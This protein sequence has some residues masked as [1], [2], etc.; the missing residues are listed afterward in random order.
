MTMPTLRSIV[1]TLV[2]ASGMVVGISQAA[3]AVFS[4]DGVAIRGYDPVAYFTESKPVKGADEFTTEWNGA[5]WKFASAANRD[6][7]LATPEKYA[8]QYGGY[9]AYGT[10]KGHLAPTQPAAW[11]VIDG[12]LYLNY[13]EQVRTRWKKDVIG[14]NAEADAVFPK[15]L[16][17][18]VEGE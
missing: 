18:P 13:N 15:L 1:A 8:P 14:Y 3:P 7:F 2:M 9:C 16:S 17:G 12:K 10:A 4:P 5:R 6:L 11:A